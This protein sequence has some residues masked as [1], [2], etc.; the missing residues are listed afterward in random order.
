[1]ICSIKITRNHF[2]SHEER[3]KTQTQDRWQPHCLLPFVQSDVVNTNKCTGITRTC[4]RFS[5]GWAANLAATI[6]SKESRGLTGGSPVLLSSQRYKLQP[7]R[8]SSNKREIYELSAAIKWSSHSCFKVIHLPE[9]YSWVTA[10]SGKKVYFPL[11][12]P[13]CVFG[14]NSWLISPFKWPRGT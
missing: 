9:K 11:C 14:D 1:M 5:S 8:S 13:A 6:H 3:K 7:E 10:P 12:N 2:S 4:A